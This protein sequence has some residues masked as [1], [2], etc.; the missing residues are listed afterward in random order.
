MF[1]S[2]FG[3]DH[4]SRILLL[5]TKKLDSTLNNALRTVS[6]CLRATPANQ[7]PILTGIAPPTLRREASV[8]ALSRKATN[9][10]DH[11]LHK[12]DT[13]TPQRAR[14]LD[15]PSQSTGISSCVRHQLMSP[16]DYGSKNAGR[17][18]GRQHTT[19]GC[20]DSWRSRK[21]SWVKIYHADSGQRLTDSDPE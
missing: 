15:V 16:K 12:T 21:N 5:H 18:S 6:G 20:T 8:L 2:I 10:D 17:K 11:L 3:R 13:E 4:V 1:V 7:L 9:D 19:P 14:R